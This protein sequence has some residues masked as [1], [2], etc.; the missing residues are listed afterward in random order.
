MEESLRSALHD[1]VVLISG[2]SRGIG[3]AMAR[4]CA[5]AGA[6]VVL[7]ARKEP[8]LEA[9]ASALRDDGYRSLAVT[10]H[11]GKVDEVSR[12]FALAR[13]TFGPVTGLVNNA[14][15]NP[16]MGPL[17]SCP[18]S[19]LDKTI[20]VNIKGYLHAIREFIKQLPTDREG[21]VVNV[22]SIAGLRAAPMQGAYAMTKAAVLSLTKTLATELSS[23][24]TRV[25]AIAPGLV[26]TRFS[27]A[28][29][30]NA[31]ILRTIVERTPLGRHGQPAEVAA[32]AVY[33]LS[34]A[35]SF[36]TGATLVIDGGLTS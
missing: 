2:A 10:C 24:R 4:A 15:T 12:A 26:E 29:I 33:L 36:T 13:D 35:S 18:D 6:A 5:E 8:E 16:H 17:L 1:R 22:S 14:A 31:P 27:Q 11:A 30:D 21:S 23:H 32:A 19:A 25:N 3:A 28:I 34:S 20:E 9:V 7:T